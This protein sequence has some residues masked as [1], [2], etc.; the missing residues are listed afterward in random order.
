MRRLILVWCATALSLAPRFVM[1]QAAAPGERVRVTVSKPA[2][3][4]LGAERWEGIFLHAVAD[5]IYVDPAGSQER[6]AVGRQ[7]LVRLERFAGREDHAGKG[8]LIG[9]AVGLGLGVLVGVL[10]QTAGCDAGFHG[11]AAE[12]GMGWWGLLVTVPVG[13]GIGAAIGAASRSDQWVEVSPPPVSVTPL[14]GR[15]RVGLALRVAF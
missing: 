1:A 7:D 15:E 11:A 2:A 3:A 4:A 12:G 10:T 6:V 13:A 9:G 5:S 8:A 14:V